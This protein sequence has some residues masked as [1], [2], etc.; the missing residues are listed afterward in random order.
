[1]LFVGVAGGLKPS[2][3]LG[4]VVVATKVHHLHPGKEAPGGFR[5]RPIPGRHVAQPGAGCRNGPVH[6]GLEGVDP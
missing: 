6:G 2:A 3:A 5:A 1:M 4:D